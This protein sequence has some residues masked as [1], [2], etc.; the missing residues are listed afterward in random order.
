MPK[1]SSA[2]FSFVLTLALTEGAAESVPRHYAPDPMI[3]IAF[4]LPEGLLFRMNGDFW[5]SSYTSPNNSFFCPFVTGRPVDCYQLYTPAITWNSPKTD[6]SYSL[7]FQ[8]RDD[9]SPPATNLRPGT[10]QIDRQ[11]H[12]YVLTCAGKIS[13]YGVL[14]ARGAE[15][16]AAQKIEKDMMNGRMRV[17][18][19][20][21]DEI[22]FRV[23]KSAQDEYFVVARPAFTD[24]DE[25]N[26]NWHVYAG[27]G[28]LWQIPAA[29]ITPDD[30]VEDSFRATP[31]G[32]AVAWP[33]NSYRR[34]DIGD[35][36]LWEVPPANWPSWVRGN[37]PGAL[38]QRA[39]SLCDAVVRSKN[40]IP[41]AH[42]PR[43]SGRGR[44]AAKHP[45]H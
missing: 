18:M 8:T 9:P 26:I 20:S 2:F 39:F 1:K 22:P 36:P 33:I 3:D 23:L 29:D 19:L 40:R 10:L 41:T 31:P 32:K 25:N 27:I 11:R 17:H 6:M 4:N 34:S 30:F 28:D 45:A 24:A 35:I 38:E 14:P 42:R 13:A 5:P 37:F 7:T 16:L 43:V 44:H 15:A 21:G 12:R